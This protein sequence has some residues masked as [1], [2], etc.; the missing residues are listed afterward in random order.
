LTYKQKLNYYIL[1]L[2]L[3]CSLLLKC[4]KWIVS[5]ITSRWPGARL[6]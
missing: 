5:Y 4:F 1:G 3:V 2:Q 6:W